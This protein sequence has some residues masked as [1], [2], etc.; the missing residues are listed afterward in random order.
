MLIRRCAL[1]NSFPDGLG[2]C[3]LAAAYCERCEVTGACQ[4]LL[5]ARF[6]EGRIAEIESIEDLVVVV[7]RRCRCV[8]GEL[9]CKG[10]FEV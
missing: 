7:S 5:D 3:R 4:Y 10:A 8:I 1:M 9:T 6:G 2:S